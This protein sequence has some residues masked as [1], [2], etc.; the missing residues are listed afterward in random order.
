MKNLIQIIF[1]FCFIVGTFQAQTK[2]I[3]NVNIFDGNNEQLIENS[4]VLIENNLIKE[5]GQNLTAPNGAEMID[6]KGKWMMPGLHE[7]HI[8]FS[9]FNPVTSGQRL[10]MTDFHVG[11]VGI[12][13]AELFLMRGYTTVR[14]LGG[15]SVHIK[16]VVDAGLSPG[17]RVF[18]SE[19][20]IT[21]TSGHV[22]MR[23]PTEPHPNMYGSPG[24]Y[25]SLD[26]S[27]S[28]VVDGP[29]EIRRA[30]RENMRRGATQIKYTGTGGVSSPSDPLHYIQFTPGEIQAMV[31]AAN[32][33]DTYVCAHVFNEKGIIRAI[34]NGVTVLE[35][36]PFL[37]DKSAKMMIENNIM[38]ATAV[39]PVLT[40]DVEDARSHYDA[41]SF[42]KW[43]T[44]RQAAENMLK[45][46]QRNPGMLK[47]MTLGS[48]LV[49]SWEKTLEEDKAMNSEFEYLAKFFKPIDILRIA[50]SNGARMNELTGPNHPYQEGKLGVVEV[51]AYAD[52]LILNSN[53]LDDVTILAEPETNILL[54]M[55]DGKIYKN[56]I[57]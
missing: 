23:N 46:I 44:V 35:H 48:D 32:D 39:A 11:A 37:T 13:R 19:A 52:L 57:E 36:I 7:Q 38:F 53:P 45:V 9:I 47:L 30:V 12:L 16:K 17:P 49:N 27:L 2:L 55:K 14:D 18:P 54:I 40:V 4:D 41:A 42:N 3:K 8:H 51:G 29:T 6:G 43:Y 1:F 21:P 5:V 20:L 56:T 25:F 15:A 50:T 33:W 24:G 26:G 10:N 28:Y 31:E 34:E 22:D